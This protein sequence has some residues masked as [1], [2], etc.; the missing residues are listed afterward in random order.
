EV[1]TK[2]RNPIERALNILIRNRLSHGGIIAPGAGLLCEGEAG[3]GMLSRWY[4]ETLSRR[5]TGFIRTIFTAE[6][7]KHNPKH[8]L[9]ILYLDEVGGQHEKL[10]SIDVAAIRSQASACGTSA[11]G[12]CA[13]GIRAGIRC[14]RCASG[15][16]L[17]VRVGRDGAE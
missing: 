7:L 3:R 5:I 4:P 15:R 1:A 8:F 9:T 11:S 16:M 12:P 13:E 17:R 14:G 6:F 10:L 2:R